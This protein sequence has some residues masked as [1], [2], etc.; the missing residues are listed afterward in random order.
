[1]ATVVALGEYANDPNLEKLVRALLK[2]LNKA[3]EQIG[4]TDT[5][6]TATT[7]SFVL[8]KQE[9]PKECKCKCIPYL[10]LRVFDSSRTVSD[11]MHFSEFDD[12][13]PCACISIER[14]SRHRRH[15][16]THRYQ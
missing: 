11:S 2:K 14:T 6:S 8:P 7:A 1:M 5:Q 13:S 16:L 12:W 3:E 15:A 4:W 9:Q 10:I